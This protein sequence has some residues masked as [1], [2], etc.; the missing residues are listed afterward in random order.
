MLKT[1]LISLLSSSLVLGSGIPVRMMKQSAIHNESAVSSEDTDEI[2]ES[3]GINVDYHSIDEIRAYV[4]ENGPV[5]LKTEYEILP[6]YENPP[7][8]PGKLSDTYLEDSLKAVNTIRY[9]AG[10]DP[11]TLNDSY[12]EMTQA[13]VLLNAVN[14]I[15]AHGGPQ[16]E[17]MDGD[18]YRLGRTGAMRSNL[19]A[20]YRTVSIAAN[21]GWLNDGHPS[22]IEDIG[23]RRWLLNADMGQTG[24]GY[25]N[26]YTG[27]Y[28]FDHT[29]SQAKT[30][31]VWPAQNTPVEM[32]DSMYPWY[33]STG[34]TEDIET[35][36]VTLTNKLT[37]DVFHFSGEQADGDFYVSNESYGVEGAVI[38]R[39]NDITYSPGDCYEVEI[40]GLANG[41]IRYTVRFFELYEK[42]EVI[43]DPPEVIM[44]AGDEQNVYVFFTPVISY[45]YI[46]KA[47]D[48]SDPFR[49]FSYAC[50]GKNNTS[51][52]EF[53]KSEPGSGTITVQSKKGV[54]GTLKVTILES[55]I[56]VAKVDLKPS[57]LDLG[58]N[59]S[60]ELKASVSP[61]NASNKYVKWTA[62]DSSVVSVDQSG[63]LKAKKPGTAVITAMS[64]D[65][66]YTDT[67]TVSVH[68][69]EY[70]TPSY[71]WADDLSSVTASAV[72]LTGKEKLE[73]TVPAVLE[74]ITAPSCEEDGYGRYTA[75]FEH[76]VFETQ[77]R[78]TDLPALGHDYVFERFNWSKNYSRANAYFV[79]SHDS[80]HNLYLDAKVTVTDTEEKTV[81]HASV[82]FEGKEYTDDYIV[83][84]TVQ[85]ESI[86]LNVHEASVT[87]G[88]SLALSAKILPKDTADQTIRWTSSDPSIAQVDANGKVTGQKGRTAVI[89][90]I[91][92]NGLKDECRVRVLFTDVSD[93]RQYYFSPVYWAAD[94]GITNGYKDSDGISRTFRPKNTCTREAVVTFLWRLAGK[95][96]PKN[97]NSPFR[98][99]QNKNAYYYK[100]VLWAAENGI[101]KGYSDGTF[102]PDKTC[103]REHV[104]T[105]LWRYAEKPEPASSRNP[106]NDVRANDY[107]YRASLWANEN[108]IAKGYSSGEY[109]GGFGPKLDCLREHVVTFL[110]RYA[111][112]K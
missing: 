41:D 62:S 83:Y 69:H 107:Y 61:E 35:V 3:V 30:S 66:G 73:E 38:F 111:Q 97:L 21:Y 45:D 91:A 17:G 9:I 60:Y 58:V 65:G 26:G 20:G 25:V 34:N 42:K 92:H 18:L 39:P 56:H 63:I 82:I 85:A 23:H 50:I 59:D 12:T 75:S 84:K 67:C 57:S 16:P 94:A 27:M 24:F 93:S 106:F 11:V 13:G 102:K 37:G 47:S 105:F 74:Y 110:Y 54:T 36:K 33:V 96:E 89:S 104:V 71:V 5:M 55:M 52:I 29:G 15:L 19:G 14:K 98:D 64:Y 90:A 100:A 77:T 8:S 88:S 31:N 108:G 87:A 22:N 101:T 10:L 112:Q 86:E 99:V 79:C 28:A 81:W 109:K 43:F 6:D 44:E 68:E 95:P 32:F 72:C 1:M 40:T 51:W 103:L 76:D 48:N 46:L 80:S 70:S 49:C 78:E 2:P 4:E 53:R 7:Y